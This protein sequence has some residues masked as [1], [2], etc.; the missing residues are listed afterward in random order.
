MYFHLQMLM[1]I[2]I[3]CYFKQGMLCFSSIMTKAVQPNSSYLLALVILTT[4]EMAGSSTWT[5]LLFTSSFSL[6]QVSPLQVMGA[7]E[8]LL[9]SLK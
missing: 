5:T 6:K 3:E 4:A 8:A 7:T 9:N 1:S 2:S